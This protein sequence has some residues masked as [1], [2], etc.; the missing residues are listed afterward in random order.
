M[1]PSKHPYTSERVSEGHYQADR[2]DYLVYC[3]HV[4]T[5]NFARAYVQDAKVLDFGCGTGYG[6]KHLSPHA[7]SILGIDISMEAIAEARTPPAPDNVTFETIPPIE[8]VPLATEDD[9]FDVVLSFQVI[10]HLP[11]VDVYLR[12]IRRVLRPGGTFICATPDR[13]VR[14]HPRQRPWN[15]FHLDEF[16]PEYL[17]AKVRSVFGEVHLHGMVSTP[18]DILEPELD[19]YR[20]MRRLSRPFTFAAAPEPWRRWGLT[21]MKRGRNALGRRRQ[22]SAACHDHGFDPTDIQIVAEARGTPNVIVVAR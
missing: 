22:A 17:E 20:T 14:L 11:D 15:V 5:Y 7:D 13:T 19:R 18:P 2:N 12:E 8:Q 9:T 21:A 4:A 1:R 16:S 6:A 10:E 3:M